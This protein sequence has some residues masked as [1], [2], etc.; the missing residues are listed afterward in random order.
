MK[1]V[2]QIYE[3]MKYIITPKDL[4]SA[5]IVFD[6]H[7]RWDIMNS[8]Q[9][10]PRIHVID[11]LFIWVNIRLQFTPSYLTLNI[12]NSLLITRINE[13]FNVHTFF[14]TH[15]S[16]QTPNKSW[17]IQKANNLL[18]SFTQAAIFHIRTRHRSTVRQSYPPLLTTSTRNSFPPNML[19]VPPPF[20]N[21]KTD[22]D[23]R[24][25]RVKTV[26]KLSL[27]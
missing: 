5:I 4:H 6:Q 11:K 22:K 24:Q 3:I 15:P 23:S 9:L 18:V 17:K 16:N 10:L 21:I 8:V 7:L 20:P 13:N 27:P 19:F 2:V 12:R 14:L 25:K 26:V 1:Y